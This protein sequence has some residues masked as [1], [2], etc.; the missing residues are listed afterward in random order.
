MKN[1]SLTRFEQRYDKPYVR[2]NI[3]PYTMLTHKQND[4]E[5]NNE[6]LHS[7]GLAKIWRRLSLGMCFPRSEGKKR[8]RSVYHLTHDPI[9]FLM[10]TEDKRE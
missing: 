4:G 6:L 1:E 2:G 9:I 8:D 10:G 5:K 3:W 7:L